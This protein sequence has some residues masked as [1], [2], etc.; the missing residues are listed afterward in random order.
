M[1]TQ[2]RNFSDSEK[3][4]ASPVYVR[5]IEPGLP[6]PGS[7]SGSANMRKSRADLIL[8][9]GVLSLFL[10]G[11]LGVIA[12]IMGTADLKK[13]RAGL[14]S[15]DKKNEIKI[16]MGLGIVGTLVSVV[17]FTYVWYAVPS[18]IFQPSEI[19]STSPLSGDHVV[20]AGEWEGNRGTVIVIHADGTGDF[21]SRHTSVRGGRVKISKDTLS[22]GLLGVYKTWHITRW[23]HLDEGRWQMD[24]DGETFT[25][26]VLGQLVWMTQSSLRHW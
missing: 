24:L 16:G 8:L 21:K 7:S 4:P 5:P 15:P 6:V 9:F 1:T 11:P 12:F 13:I 18:H 3:G 17:V 20:F 26:K 14:L 25:R 2:T 23:P 22:I 19:G 10:C